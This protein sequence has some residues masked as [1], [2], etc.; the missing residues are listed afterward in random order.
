S[1]SRRLLLEPDLEAL[2]QWVRE[3]LGA[4]PPD[5]GGCLLGSVGIELEVDDPP[6]ARGL[7]VEAEL[8]KGV[9]DRL[10]LRVEDALLRSHEHCC[11]HRTT[12]G[13]A[14]YA[15]NEISV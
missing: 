14:Q 8:A 2:D 4:H 10:A 15:S 1:P 9:P 12:S 11:S 13:C 5:L 3:E 6:D 7:D